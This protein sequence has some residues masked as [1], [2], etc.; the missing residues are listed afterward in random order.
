MA[1]YIVINEHSPD[2]CSAMEAAIPKLPPE[3][4]G[5]DFYCTCP[6]GVHGYFMIFEGDSAEEVLGIVPADDRE[7]L[8]REAFRAGV[9]AAILVQRF[10]IYGEV[11]CSVC[12]ST[13]ADLRDALDRLELR[14][15]KSSGRLYRHQSEWGDDHPGNLVII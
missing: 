14:P 9:K 10:Q 7:A 4:K 6:G 8:L 2:Q 15:V 12:G 3:L 13:W 1:Q 5:T 11:W